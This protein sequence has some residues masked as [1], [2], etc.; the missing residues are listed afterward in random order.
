[1]RWSDTAMDSSTTEAIEMKMELLLNTRASGT[2]TRDMERE[3]QSSQMEASIG[4][5]LSEMFSLVRALT[6]G[7][8]VMYTLDNSRM[9]RW[10]AL[11][12]SSTAL[13]ES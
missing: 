10:K 2:E 1:M 13:V 4:V 12:I 3:Q 9:D 11:V 7:P 5:G 6:T 8:K